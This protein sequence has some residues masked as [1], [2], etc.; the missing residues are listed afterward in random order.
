MASARSSAHTDPADQRLGFAAMR[1]IP[2]AI[3]VMRAV[4]LLPV[5]VLIDEGS[6]ALA[7]AVFIGAALTDAIDGPVSRRLGAVTRAGAF[8]DPLADKILILGTLLALLGQGAVAEWTVA[9]I[10]SREALALALRGVAAGLGGS[11]EASAPGKAKTFVQGVAVAL[12]LLSLATGSP[13][14]ASLAEAAL[15]GAVVLTVASGIDLG[16][17]SLSLAQSRHV[18]VHAR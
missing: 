3:S 12:S 9:I 17:R 4:A 7:A 11:L 1:A 15:L 16:R 13:Y 5:V 14:L 8:L 2:N 10:L 6:I 18:G